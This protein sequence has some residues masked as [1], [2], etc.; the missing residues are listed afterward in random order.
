MSMN[1]HFAIKA[2]LSNPVLGATVA[3]IAKFKVPNVPQVIS[4]LRKKGHEV[5][6]VKRDG[7]MYYTL[8][9]GTRDQA[10]KLTTGQ[11]E[12]IEISIGFQQL[13]S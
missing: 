6:S 8:P 12:N 13:F 9:Y 4:Q 3:D 2:I 1:Q 7:K 5:I 11:R 10:A